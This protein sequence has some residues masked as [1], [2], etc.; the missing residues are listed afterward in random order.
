MANQSKK[1]QLQERKASEVAQNT[2]SGTSADN[3]DRDQTGDRNRREGNDDQVRAVQGGD[4]G[5]S[6][7]G[8]G[9]KREDQS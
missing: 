1:R 3:S 8:G 7:G 9:K 4:G 6:G 5:T 2:A